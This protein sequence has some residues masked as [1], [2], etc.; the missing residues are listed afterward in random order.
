MTAE[1][2]PRAQTYG[3]VSASDKLAGLSDSDDAATQDT[4]VVG[5]IKSRV[6]RSR[7]C[8]PRPVADTYSAFSRPEMEYSVVPNEAINASD[9]GD[10]ALPNVL[11]IP[12][13]HMER[14]G[15]GENME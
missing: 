13:N 6:T 10:A 9:A 15:T 8:H 4:T 1:I 14:V 12:E 11:P 5:S 3:G 2:L 7:C